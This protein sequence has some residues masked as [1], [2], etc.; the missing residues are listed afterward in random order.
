MSAVPTSEHRFDP[1]DGWCSVHRT[2][3]S[4]APTDPPDSLPS[5]ADGAAGGEAETPDPVVRD[6]AT[7]TVSETVDGSKRRK[8]PRRGSRNSKV[9]TVRVRKDIWAAAL[10]ACRP[11]EHLKIV[12]A[13]KVVTEYD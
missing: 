7:V 9:R 13:D 5:R 2:W 6:T 10:A 3:C 12:S 11:G 8:A 4:Q 1:S